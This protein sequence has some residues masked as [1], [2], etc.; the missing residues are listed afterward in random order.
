[1]DTTQNEIIQQ[2]TDAMRGYGIEPPPRIL[3]D[4]NLHRFHVKTH[5]PGSLNGA[6]KLHLDGLRPAG[7]IQDYQ[8]GLKVNWKFQGELPTYTEEEKRAYALQQRQKAEQQQRELLARQQAAATKAASIWNSAKPATE[9]AYLTKKGI[10]P[11]KARLYNNALIIPLYNAQMRLMNL[12]FIAADGAK[13][14]LSGGQK[15]ECFWCLGSQTEKV[16]I[17]EGFA[18]G[19]SLFESTGYQ[20]FIAFDAG[21]LAPVAQVIRAKRPSATIIVCA[22]NDESGRGQEAATEAALLVGGLLCIPPKVGQD[23]NDWALQATKD[24]V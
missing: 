23:F 10:Q 11:H 19:A 15:K 12:Q 6:Y 3:A 16:L 1:M 22:D 14:F 18:T 8:S 7:F 9:H 24:G 17:C 2:F 20:T 21:N 4:G 13:R 5:K